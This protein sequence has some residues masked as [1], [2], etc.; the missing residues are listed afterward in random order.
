MRTQHEAEQAAAPRR[1]LGG[2]RRRKTAPVP[3]TAA[4]ARPRAQ[5]A[6][7]LIAS[8]RYKSEELF[9]TGPTAARVTRSERDAAVGT[10]VVEVLLRA[11]AAVEDCAKGLNW[12]VYGAAEERR[13]LCQ[14]RA[15]RSHIHTRILGHGYAGHS[16]PRATC[17]HAQHT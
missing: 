9:A 6:A 13:G 3:S 4:L 12:C 5:G 7:T 14:R 8:Y 10:F 15:T 11:A 17:P 1:A 2:R 16:S